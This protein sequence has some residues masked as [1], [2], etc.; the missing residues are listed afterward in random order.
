MSHTRSNTIVQGVN[1]IPFNYPSLGLTSRHTII[2]GIRAVSGSQ[3]EVYIS[4]GLVGVDLPQ[5]VQT[6]V[7]NI[8]QGFIYKGKLEDANKLENWHLLHYKL[9]DDDDDIVFNTSCYGPNN[10]E[11]GTIEI[12]GAYIK[13]SSPKNN[14][15]FYYNGPIDGS[16][17]WR[18]V[19]P[20]N[21]NNKN[22]FMHSVMGGLAVGNY[23][24][25]AA[26][27]NTINVN[28]FVYDIKTQECIDFI[29]DDLNA[30][31]LYG[32]WHNGGNSYTMAG[33][34]SARKIGDTV[35]QAFLVDYDSSTKT[36]NNLQFFS[37]HNEITPTVN[38]H[39]E[40]IT[41]NKT[42]DGYNMP[43]DWSKG[44]KEGASFVTVKRN[45][46]GTFGLAEWK[47][48]A[49][50]GDDVKI[51]SANTVYLDNVL[52]IYVSKSSDETGTV[53]SSY[54]ATIIE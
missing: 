53:I 50:P 40:G 36:F 15:G 41:I 14:L 23:Q 34:N 19:T 9:E 27:E 8:W 33:G 29:I 1:Y 47:D 5:E 52:G 21:G 32:I 37:Y 43:G 44:A 16:G 20:N 22:V 3:H 13:S 31:T 17:T 45:K 54:C 18:T 24:S 38:V 35:S 10:G 6:E 12:V 39:F 28:A 11:N 48:I 30:P 46:N 49:Y 26:D 51:T 7:K 2:E 4:G 42:N 25:D